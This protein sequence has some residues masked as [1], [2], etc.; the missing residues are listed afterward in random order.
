MQEYKFSSTEKVFV[1]ITSPII[2][3]L[4]AGFWLSPLKDKSLAGLIFILAIIFI[5]GSCSILAIVE[6]FKTKL[7]IEDDKIIKTGIFRTTTLDFKDIDGFSKNI[8]YTEIISKE[9]KRKIILTNHY[10]N[11][12]DLQSFLSQNFKNLD[13]TENKEKGSSLFVT[14]YKEIKYI[15]KEFLKNKEFGK[16]SNEVMRRSEKTK[17]FTEPFNLIAFAAFI[18]LL[19]LRGNPI[20]VMINIFIPI[21]ALFISVKSRGFIT[22]IKDKITNQPTLSG[23]I[24]GSPFLL[25][26][27]V[28]MSGYNV[29]SYKA[30]WLPLIIISI[31]GC[32]TIIKIY[33]PMRKESRKAKVFCLA[34][35]SIL[36][37]AYLFGAA[38]HIN[39]TFDIKPDE[40]ITEKVLEKRRIRGRKRTSYTITVTDWENETEVIELD[41]SSRQ[42]YTLKENSNVNI[43]QKQGLLGIPWCYVQRE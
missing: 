15:K 27:S 22:I 14:N 25:C 34:A 24:V 43:V 38:I 8:L 13:S 17:K 26:I 40:I 33:K 2:I 6:A 35:G 16:N 41:I 32:F 21:I 1:A 36:I 29:Y 4:G 19:I 42:F 23:A 12:P 9:K 37:G 10:S 30:I 39:C 28:F 7:V 11:I 18:A 5:F 3:A 31:T 20:I